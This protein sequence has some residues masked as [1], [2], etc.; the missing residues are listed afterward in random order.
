MFNV[1][2]GFN[3]GILNVGSNSCVKIVDEDG[4]VEGGIN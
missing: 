3:D 1:I 2:E 4:D